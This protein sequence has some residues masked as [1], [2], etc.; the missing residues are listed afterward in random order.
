MNKTFNKILAEEV[1]SNVDRLKIKDPGQVVTVLKELF[2]LNTN[3]LINSIGSVESDTKNGIADES[4]DWFV[5]TLSKSVVEKQEEWTKAIKEIKAKI[6]TNKYFSR[7]EMIGVDSLEAYLRKEIKPYW[8]ALQNYTDLED[9]KNKIFNLPSDLLYALVRYL[10]S[11][12]DEL[13][14]KVK[15]SNADLRDRINTVMQLRMRVAERISQVSNGYQSVLDMKEVKEL[16]DNGILFE[17]NFIN[18]GICEFVMKLMNHDDAAKRLKDTFAPSMLKDLKKQIEMASSYM[19]HITSI[20]NETGREFFSTKG[21]QIGKRFDN[22]VDT[23]KNKKYDDVVIDKDS[24]LKE[25]K[26]KLSTVDLPWES[27]GGTPAGGEQSMDGA[28]GGPPGGGAPSDGGSGGFGGGGGGDFDMGGDFAP[29]GTEGEIP[30]EE[31]EEGTEGAA[32]E[33]DGTPMPDDETGL[34]ADFGTVED[35]TGEEA[36]AEEPAEKSDKK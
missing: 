27:G 14:D 15:V 7:K 25:P 20:K 29:P 32:P 3:K 11:I 33:A 8:S 26:E 22:E 23:V 28:A 21:E 31:G 5:D 9:F 4:W 36:P 34:P 16:F 19:E 12:S 6:L 10:F 1:N 17:D 35:N 30:G 2:F 24:R 13:K 18:R